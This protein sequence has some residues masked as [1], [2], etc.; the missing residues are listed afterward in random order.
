MK[1][2]SDFVQFNHTGEKLYLKSFQNMDTGFEWADSQSAC[3]ILA[4]EN[5]TELTEN[6]HDWQIKEEILGECRVITITA[7]HKNGLVLSCQYK[8]HSDC[9]VVQIGCTLKNI[10]SHPLCITNFSPVNISLQCAEPVVAYSIRKDVYSMQTQ[11]MEDPLTIRG[12]KWNMPENAGWLVL[13]NTQ[14]Q[15]S[16]FLGIEWEREWNLSV[17]PDPKG[18]IVLKMGLENFSQTLEEGGVLTSPTVF[19][20]AATGGLDEATNSMRRYMVGHVLPQPMKDFPWVSYDIWS[21]ESEDVEETIRKEADFA[22]DIGVENFYIDASWWAGSSVEGDGAWG[23]RLGNYLPDRRKFPKG[24]R[25]MAEYVHGKGMKFG[26]WVDPMIIDEYWVSTGMIPEKWLVKNQDEHAVLDL[27]EVAGWPRVKQICTGCKEV[28]NYIVEIVSR[29]IEEFRLDWIKWDDSAFS[30]PVVCTRTDHGHQ[31]GDGNYM[32]VAGKYE[33]F[34]ELH[35]RFPDLVIEACGYPARIDYGLAPY[36]RTSWLSDSS[37]PA[38]KVINNMEFASYVY[39]NSYNSAWLIEH[40]EVLKES[41]PAALDTVV[42]SRMMGLFGFGTLTGHLSERIS[43]WPAAVHDAI[44]RNLPYYKTMRHLLSQ[45]VYH[46]NNDS[47]TCCDWRMMACVSYDK[48]QAVTFVF[49]ADAE[50]SSGKIRLKGLD[51]A[52]DYTVSS[53]NTGKTVSMSGKELMTKGVLVDL[54]VHG[55]ASDIFEAKRQA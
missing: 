22:A 12:G 29:I 39:P 15:E 55:Q 8:I 52:V 20:G 19:L 23:Y 2:Y 7:S 45:D 6:W 25:A 54:S 30:Q 13:E 37:A 31:E 10:G 46:Y 3:G 35:E 33:I 27:T 40:D 21:T 18:H 42:R 53:L 24:L 14:R 51:A 4:E 34:K 36:I 16:L 49:R 17:T 41:D 11:V 5:G 32:A 48:E 50:Q 1:G 26:I 43:L 44:R 47:D 38:E 28:Q 9:Q